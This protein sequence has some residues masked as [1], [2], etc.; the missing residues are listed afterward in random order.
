MTTPL[1]LLPPYRP[2]SALAYVYSSGPKAGTGAT[3]WPFFLP[4]PGHAPQP[5]AGC[6]SG[7]NHNDV[8]IFSESPKPLSNLNVGKE[9]A[10]NLSMLE[11][12]F[13]K[14]K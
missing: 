7:L 11:I 6:Q 5:E 14:Q 1:G 3:L 2:I 9:R 4:H 10:T 8:L 12:I 13:L